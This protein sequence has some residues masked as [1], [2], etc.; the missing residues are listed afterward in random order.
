MFTS[1]WLSL[2]HSLKSFRTT[3]QYYCCFTAPGAAALCAWLL[4]ASP[5]V[6]QSLLLKFKVSLFPFFLVKICLFPVLRE[7][8]M[9]F[10]WRPCW[11]LNPISFE[12]RE[13]F[14]KTSS[15]WRNRIKNS[16]VYCVLS[17]RCFNGFQSN[18][19]RVFLASNWRRLNEEVCFFQCC[20]HEWMTGIVCSYFQ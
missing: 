2:S 7:F 19:S 3:L 10:L 4:E 13:P 12:A 9:L 18:S 20:D 5:K 15:S 16:Q 17:M 8:Q 14:A 6:I 1:I 11:W